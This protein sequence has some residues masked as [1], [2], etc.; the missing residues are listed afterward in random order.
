MAYP[1]VAI[2]IINWNGWKDTLECLESLYQINYPNYDVIL[3]DNNSEDT[4]IEKIKDYCEGKIKVQSEFFDPYGK[5]IKLFQYKNSEFESSEIKDIDKFSISSSRRLI[6]I[7]NDKNYGFAEG[8]NI[9]MRYAIK[10]L[11]PDYILLLNNDTVVNNV[12]LTEMVSVAESD[13]QIGFVGPKVY[14][15]HKK[16]ILQ[17][18]GGSEVDLKHGEVSEMAYHYAD[19]GEYDHYFEPDF[20]G[21]TCMLVKMKVI[22][23]VGLLDPNYFMYWEDADWC[24]RGLKYGYKSAYAFKSKI[25]HKYGASSRNPFKIYYFTRN[26]IYFMKKNITRAQFIQFSLFLA[27]VTL[28]KSLIQLFRFRDY[29]MSNAFFKGFVDGLKISL[30]TK[31]Y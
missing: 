3:I 16:N 31:N 9:G 8:N 15:Y 24:F 17:V 25:W 5:P 11:N 23:N 1:R 7:K 30:S 6:L 18:A 4:S 12:F 27:A 28:Y 29:E 19:E 2:I 22:K 26:R 10:E 13:D 21:G 14:I 20:I